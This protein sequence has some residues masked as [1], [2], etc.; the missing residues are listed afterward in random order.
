MG[1]G[2][3][4]GV[5]GGAKQH[6]VLSHCRELAVW[7]SCFGMVVRFGFVAESHGVS[8]IHPYFFMWTFFRSCCTARRLLSFPFRFCVLFTTPTTSFHRQLLLVTSLLLVAFMTSLCFIAH[9]NL[10]VH[11]IVWYE[12]H[13]ARGQYQTLNVVITS[14]TLIYYILPS[15][16]SSTI[17]LLDP[18]FLCS[19][20]STLANQ[21]CWT[22]IYCN[23]YI[24]R[25]HFH[26]VTWLLDGFSRYFLPSTW[27]PSIV[28]FVSLIVYHLV[29]SL[30]LL[31]INYSI[32]DFTFPFMS[33]FIDTRNTLGFSLRRAVIP[34]F[35]RGHGCHQSTWQ[36][37]N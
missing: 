2:F 12:Y 26:T 24:R 32:C 14:S 28:S 4:C 25:I 20:V 23:L 6:V 5:C 7:V 16:D 17:I 36:D 19:C 29:S 18:P 9:D 8:P 34:D 15:C 11:I 1:I 33:M 37:P 31:L 27:S 13:R 21:Y 3:S 10:L 30:P 35:Y 22:N